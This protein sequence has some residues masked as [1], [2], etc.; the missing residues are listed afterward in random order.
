M[1]ALKIAAVVLLLGV[2][3]W[4]WEAHGR[5]GTERTL[6]GAASEL[7]GRPVHVRCQS[8]WADLFSVH[9][10]LG[11][12]Q[13]DAQGRPSDSTWLTRE[14]CGR[15]HR[16]VSSHGRDLSCLTAVDWS[17]FSWAQPHDACIDRA[18]PI[19]Q[20][21]VTLTHEAMH[22]RGVRSE[23]GAQC[24]AVQQVAWTVARLGG[25]PATGTPLA[26]LARA[27]SGWM[28]SEYQLGNCPES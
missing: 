26:K 20:A 23:S 7:A 28:P 1:T 24:L 21:V 17:R 9:G 6:S 16:F 22:L 25:D 10:E 18:A 27:W 2:G 13:F 12:V 3:A 19:G 15:L 8:L 14:S 5:S 4:A 11:M